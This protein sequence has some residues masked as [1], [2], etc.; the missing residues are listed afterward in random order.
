MMFR[1]QDAQDVYLEQE[2]DRMLTFK[3]EMLQKVIRGWRH[4]R[5]F[6]HTKQHCIMLQSYVRSFLCAKKYQQV[7]LTL[8]ICLLL[9][10]L[11][12]Q[13]TDYY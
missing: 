10:L 3:I 5:Q 7:C 2:R 12:L 1:C 8:V 9:L 4:R 11:L 13:I 6:R